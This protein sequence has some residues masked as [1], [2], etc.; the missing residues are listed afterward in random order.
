M[1]RWKGLQPSRGGSTRNLVNPTRGRGAEQG[2]G[3]G[4]GQNRGKEKEK[5]K[6]Q[7][8]DEAG[9]LLS[10]IYK[11][12]PNNNLLCFAIP[13]RAALVYAGPGM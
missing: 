12:T 5:V 4:P 11:E 8:W 7:V 10:F 6:C 13:D 3:Q 2:G 1:A 9:K